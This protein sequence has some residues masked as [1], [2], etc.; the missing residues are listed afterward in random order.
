MGFVVAVEDAERL[1]VGATIHFGV[2]VF[3]GA[4]GLA[5]TE[6]DCLIEQP[7]GELGDQP[8]GPLPQDAA[9]VRSFD[10]EYEPVRSAGTA[11]RFGVELQHAQILASLPRD[12]RLR[13][14]SK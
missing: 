1:S 9:V 11:P 3:G 7:S 2:E 4:H 5:P 8:V 12:V 10:V 14:L 13:A 6:N